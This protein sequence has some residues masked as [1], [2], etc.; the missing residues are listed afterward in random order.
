[1]SSFKLK[2]KE[3]LF[4]LSL[5]AGLYV[6]TCLA[7][8]KHYIGESGN[9]TPRLN[10]H[11]NKLRRGYHENQA[12]QKDF[13]LYGEKLFIFQKLL[14][15]AGLSKDQRLDLENLILL[16]LPSEYRYNV[17]VNW[18]KREAILNP[19]FGKIHSKEAR[20]SQSLAKMGQPSPFAG[21]TQT[22]DVK[23]FI[24]QINSGKKDR[25]KPLFI[26]FDYYESVSEA[27]QKTG[28]N[29]RLIRERCHSQ[30]LRFANY[31]WA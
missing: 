12:L 26:N 16:T 30:A 7:N 29:R 18:R 31:T 2:K 3:N 21:H 23:L 8:R 10:A 17:Y 20:K 11:K 25:R 24:S 5:K 4:D 6:I 19:F 13:H 1:M 22:N 27:S 28:L 14:L 15:G 9:V